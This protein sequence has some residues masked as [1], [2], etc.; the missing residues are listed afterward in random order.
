MELMSRDHALELA[1]QMI[2]STG[3]EPGSKPLP[4]NFSYVQHSQ[5]PE[6][7][8]NARSVYFSI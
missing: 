2:V 1:D 4:S 7:R 5:E 8:S 6:F 3:K